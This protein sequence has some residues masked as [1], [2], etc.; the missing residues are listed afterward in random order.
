MCSIEFAP[1]ENVPLNENR[2]AYFKEV[3][4]RMQQY[5]VGFLYWRIEEGYPTPDIIDALIA[6]NISPPTP[7]V[8]AVNLLIPAG[9]VG[10]LGLL[11][12]ATRKRRRR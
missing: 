3:L 10:G 6:T 9:I 2:M 12:V 1:W 8:Q 5:R 4:K 7:P 11:W